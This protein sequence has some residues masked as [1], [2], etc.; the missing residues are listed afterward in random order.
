MVFG[1]LALAIIAAAIRAVANL[2]PN[3]FPFFAPLKGPAANGTDLGGAFGVMG[4][5]IRVGMGES[6]IEAMLAPT[7]LQAP[8]PAPVG[9]VAELQQLDLRQANA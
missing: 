3:R 7:I 1:L 5:Q 8:A 6:G 4:H 2:I 9:V